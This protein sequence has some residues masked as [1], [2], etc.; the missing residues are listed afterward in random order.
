MLADLATLQLVDPMAECLDTALGSVLG[1][2][3][4]LA[5]LARECL[6]VGD[7]S[8]KT[9]IQIVRDEPEM[10]VLDVFPDSLSK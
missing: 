7:S 1:E 2:T 3:K 10:T 8:F 4:P 5:K 6:L 9:Y